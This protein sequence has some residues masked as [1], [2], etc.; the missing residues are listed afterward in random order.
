MQLT[1]TAQQSSRR[2]FESGRVWL[3]P[4]FDRQLPA[5]TIAAMIVVTIV[6]MIP[7]TLAVEIDQSWRRMS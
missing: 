2:C 7:A 4:D 5:E 6:L 1:T 3:R